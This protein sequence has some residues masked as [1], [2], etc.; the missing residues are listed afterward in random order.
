MINTAEMKQN[1]PIIEQE[2]NSIGNNKTNIHCFPSFVRT[3]TFL[4]LLIPA[5]THK[6]YHLTH[7]RYVISPSALSGKLFS[8]DKG[9]GDVNVE[10]SLLSSAICLGLLVIILVSAN[11]I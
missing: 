9:K 2:W 6:N 8:T 3:A 7:T 5:C 10:P 1:G 11:K 4:S